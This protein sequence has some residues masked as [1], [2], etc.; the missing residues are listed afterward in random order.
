[1]DVL[2]RRVP[3][4]LHIHVVL[5]NLGSHKGEMVQRW[6]RRHPRFA[7][8]FVPTS[9]SWRNMV[10][11]WL[12]HPQQQPLTPRSFHSVPKLVEAIEEYAK[13]SND[14]A[15]P[16]VWTQS[17]DEILRKVRKIRQLLG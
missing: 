11:G 3:S 9:S 17:A 1:M 2:D 10:E 8:H 5:H 4:D 14:A 15:H 16:W 7:L 13:V 6:L 12:G